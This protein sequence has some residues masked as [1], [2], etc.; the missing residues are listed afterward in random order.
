MAP[1]T[2]HSDG[3]WALALA[4]QVLGIPAD[5]DRI[6]H[7]SGKSGELCEAELLRAARRFPAKAKAV[8]AS[9]SRLARLPLPAL[10][11]LRAGG[12]VVVGKVIE[13]QLLLQ[14]QQDARPKTLTLDGFERQWTGRLILITRRAPL[15]DPTRRFDLTW[16]WGAVRAGQSFGGRR[17]RAMVPVKISSLMM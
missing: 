8:D 10:A 13:N 4:L 17:V 16:F 12:Y 7:D 3:A 11:E 1:T 15:S 14:G 9:I 2:A 6:R 5:P